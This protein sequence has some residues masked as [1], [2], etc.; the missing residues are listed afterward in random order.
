MF[1]DCAHEAERAPQPSEGHS[2]QMMDPGGLPPAGVLTVKL[3]S[4]GGTGLR[5][6]GPWN[7]GR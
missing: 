3:V 4:S 2:H 1:E 7:P 6:M 5:F